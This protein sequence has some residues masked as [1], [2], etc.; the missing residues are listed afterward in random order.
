M[1]SKVSQSKNGQIIGKMG[2]I[3]ERFEDGSSKIFQEM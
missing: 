1:P 3:G 2:P